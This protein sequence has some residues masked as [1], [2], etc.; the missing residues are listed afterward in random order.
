MYIY[1]YIWCQTGKKLAQVFEQ[2]K[3]A[4]SIKST[5]TLKK[6]YRRNLF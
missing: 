3:S 1:I 6:W 4:T 5:S 2:Q